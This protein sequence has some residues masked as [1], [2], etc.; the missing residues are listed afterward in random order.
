MGSRI[1]ATAFD[2]RD[3]ELVSFLNV[4]DIDN[5]TSRRLKLP[6]GVS[7]VVDASWAKGQVK[8]RAS[9]RIAS[10]S[11]D[12]ASDA[13]LTLGS[14]VFV[15]EMNVGPATRPT[16]AV[17]ADRADLAI[18]SSN[19]ITLCFN[20]GNRHEIKIPAGANLR[21]LRAIDHDNDGWLDIFTANG[22]VDETLPAGGTVVVGSTGPKLMRVLAAL[23]AR[24][25]HKSRCPD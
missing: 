8:A 17:K 16:I 14:G 12:Q 7:G 25:R 10:G 6:S 21:S 22:H 1:I 5:A 23:R 2:C 24:T 15:G 13:K 19:T 3:V 4:R 20:G 11:I 9:L 18:L